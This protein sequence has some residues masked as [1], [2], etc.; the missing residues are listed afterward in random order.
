MKASPADIAFSR[1][2]RERANYRCEKCGAQHDKSSM[3][4]HCSHIFSRRHRTVRWC[5]DNA[6]ALDYRCHAWYG[7]NAADSGLWITEVLG[8]GAI[9][10]LREKINSRAK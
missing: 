2:V 7:G 5:A 9:D 1:C 3:G 6:Q 8:K 10:L 4:L